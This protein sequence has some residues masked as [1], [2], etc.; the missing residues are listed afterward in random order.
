MPKTRRN[1]CSQLPGS[2]RGAILLIVA[3]GAAFFL[4]L[5]A[6]VTDIGW[7]YYHQIKLQ[8]AINAGWKA[9]FDAMIANTPRQQVIEHIK[10][11]VCLNYPDTPPPEVA[12]TFAGS[13]QTEN[14][15]NQDSLFLA[16]TGTRTVHLFFAKIFG[17]ASF[18]VHAARSGGIENSSESGIIPLAIPHGVT[19]ETSAGTYICELFGPGGGFSSG[20]EYL[21]RLSEPA[22][23]LPT[24][25]SSASF[26]N[27]AKRIQNCG[28]IDPDNSPGNEI[29][30]YANRLIRGYNRPLQINDRIILQ[31]GTTGSETASC[32]AVRIARGAGTGILPITDIPPEVAS[33]T[34]NLGARTIY[35][36]RGM[37]FPG[38]KYSRSEFPFTTAVRIIGFAEFE[39]LNPAESGSPQKGQVRGRFIR[40]I[41]RPTDLHE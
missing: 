8:T 36:I 32:I 39:L 23:G 14:A 20:T 9:G 25:T 22:K 29:S 19:T 4:G 3:F 15:E 6:L 5:L 16:V 26:E 41:I 27:G 37:D 35:D 13:D 2:N 33:A 24:D 21:L 28:S 17:L 30:E 38:G 18:R 12:V 11:V 7:T 10:S 1:T 31:P 34:P 40:Y